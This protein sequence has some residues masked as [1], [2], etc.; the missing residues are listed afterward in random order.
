VSQQQAASDARAQAYADMVSIVSKYNKGLAKSAE[1]EAARVAV[2][3]NLISDIEATRGV[4]V[5][6]EEG[7]AIA[8]QANQAS[9]RTFMMRK[10]VWHKKAT[11]TAKSVVCISTNARLLK[12]LNHII[13]GTPTGRS[14]NQNDGLKGPSLATLK[15]DAESGKN[16]GN[17]F[18]QPGPRTRTK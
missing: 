10:I 13:N 11:E 9:G 17:P 12:A 14:V 7:R 6:E 15:Y 4:A 2:V 8:A 5:S 3:D 1:L 18:F 16:E